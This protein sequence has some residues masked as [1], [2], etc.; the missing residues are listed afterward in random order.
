MV[1]LAMLQTWNCLLLCQAGY[2][3][4]GHAYLVLFTAR[5][6][7]STV[8][9]VSVSEC[10]SHAGNVSKQLNLASFKRCYITIVQGL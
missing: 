1:R 10:L 6:Y 8:Y 5:R 3:R 2:A 7:A 4:L 9:V